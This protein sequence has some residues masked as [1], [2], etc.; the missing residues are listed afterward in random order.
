MKFCG[1]CGAAQSEICP[2]CKF[3]NPP[4]FKF[5]GSCGSSLSMTSATPA[6]HEIP[7]KPRE[8]LSAERGERRHLTVMFCDLVGSTELSGRLDPEDLRG[9]VRKYQDVCEKV[10]ARYEGH[11]AQYLG[12]GIL[13]YFGYPVAH[14]NDAHRAVSSGLGILE[15]IERLNDRLEAEGTTRIS[16][17]LGVHTGHVVIGDIGQSGQ[18]QQLALGATP[19]IAARIQ[20][21]ADPGGLLISAE[22][23]QLVSRYFVCDDQGAYDAK[24]IAEPLRVY[25]VRQENTAL[26]RLEDGAEREESVPMVG[27]DSEIERLIGLWEEAKHGKSHVVLL[28]G[29]AGLGKSRIIRALMQHVAQDNDAWLNV[30]HCSPYHQRTA[31]Y[32]ISNT[33]E[34]IVLKFKHGESSEERILKLE[35][36]LLQYGLPLDETVPLFASILTIPLKGT[37]YLPSP[38]SPEQ[39]KQK[40]IATIMWA[41]MERARHQT[42]LLIFED[43]QWIDPSTLDLI[44]QIV[45]QSPVLNMLT[46][47]SFRPEFT[48]PWRL[49]PHVVPTTLTNLPN[50]AVREIIQKVAGGKRLPDALIEEIIRKTDGVPLFVEELAKMVIGSDMLEAFEDHYE[51]TG[52]IS[53]LAI[54]S[55]LHDS[56]VARLDRMSHTKQIA[57]LGAAIGRD[58]SYALIN[59]ASEMEERAV[60][61]GLNEL[62]EA[63][64]LQQQG[65]APNARYNFRHAL[66]RDAAYQSLLKSQKKVMHGRIANSIT[67][68]L[69]DYEMEHPEIAAYHYEQARITAKAIALWTRAGEKVKQ[70]LGYDEALN[71]LERGLSL[72]DQLPD[73]DEKARLE[74]E[75]LTMQAPVY[76][77]VEGFTSTKAHNCS[78]RMKE[79]AE[80]SGDQMGLFRALRGVIPYTVFTGKP[81]KALAFARETLAIAESQQM[82]DLK[83]EALRLV[84]QSSVY[85]AENEQSLDAFDQILEIYKTLDDHNLGRLVGADPDIFS[86]T[87][88]SHVIWTL[89]YPDQA[90]DRANQAIN[91]AEEGKRRFSQA[92]CLCISSFLQNRIG[93]FEGGQRVAIECIALCQK[94]GILMFENEVSIFLGRAMARLGDVNAGLEVMHRAIDHRIGQGMTSGLL[95]HYSD[96]A[97]VYLESGDV[98]NGLTTV[99]LAIAHEEET[100]DRMFLPEVYRVKGELLLAQN[101]QANSAAAE[102]CYEKS[103]KEAQTTSAR[104]LELRTAMSIA[105]LRAKQGRH[106]EGLQLVK[107]I[108]DWFAEGFETI[109]L[110]EAGQLMDALS[111]GAQSSA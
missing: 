22:T 43:L 66:I 13:V 4:G 88:S 2:S 67:T 29:E 51:L 69:P 83:M 62:V 12:D 78:Q 30:H 40:L 81:F 10:V 55:T 42:L 20:G 80:A 74:I 7:A 46:V 91:R 28:N 16:V 34:H 27:R 72:L 108:Y 5:C 96:L 19:N 37:A 95:Y 39:Q 56:L 47:L 32:P 25:Q 77:M 18:A 73:G 65:V 54:P 107:G 98:E 14:E 102:G 101:F 24:G 71:F 41:F 3:E 111:T 76:L 104:S 63:E 90:I 97:S 92:M 44:T 84:G 52:P 6:V 110:K 59:Y 75:I 17:R 9:I 60:L 31:F 23:Y 105:R 48:P 100:E 87:Q 36:F 93:D 57:Q 33:L 109:D 45:N 103:L 38:F 11:I 49:Q 61:Q 86:L 64:L 89:G 99:R 1:N 85:T 35:G 94:Y 106:A 26:S 79:L 58:F 8:Q 21:L 82:P 68:H 15:A 53:S 50:E 70:H